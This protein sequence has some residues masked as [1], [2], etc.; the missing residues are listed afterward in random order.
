V[1]GF[2]HNA[3]DRASFG[4]LPKIVLLLSVLVPF[5]LLASGKSRC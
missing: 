2:K 3:I 5:W 1:L 4:L